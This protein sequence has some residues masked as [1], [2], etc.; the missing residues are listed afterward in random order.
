M[1]RRRLD[2]K[3]EIAN[4]IPTRCILLHSP[5]QIDNPRRL[6]RCEYA[7]SLSLPR[8]LSAL[9]M[10]EIGKLSFTCSS[11][12]VPKHAD[13]PAGFQA[14]PGLIFAALFFVLCRCRLGVRLAHL[15]PRFPTL[16]MGR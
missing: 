2:S 11:E 16:G 15:W 10:R 1:S 3:I 6:D 13:R 7:I 9:S 14:A 5:C 4:G 12:A 8:S